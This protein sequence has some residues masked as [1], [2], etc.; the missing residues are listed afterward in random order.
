MSKKAIE[1]FKD[2]NINEFI[3]NIEKASDFLSNIKKIK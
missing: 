1:D 2:S 3:K